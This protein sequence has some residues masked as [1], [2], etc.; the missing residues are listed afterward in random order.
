MCLPHY[1][2]PSS[3]PRS[4]AALKNSLFCEQQAEGRPVS[5]EFASCLLSPHCAN[6]NFTPFRYQLVP[7]TAFPLYPQLLQLV[8]PMPSPLQHFQPSHLA[9]FKLPQETPKW[10]NFLLVTPFW[11]VTVIVPVPLPLPTSSAML[12]TVLA[13]SSA[14]HQTAQMPRLPSL[15]LLKPIYLPSAKALKKAV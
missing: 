12:A 4:V 3:F 13:Q 10:W 15:L 1:S 7:V 6:P 2:M 8:P 14:A 11:P 9:F 5:Y